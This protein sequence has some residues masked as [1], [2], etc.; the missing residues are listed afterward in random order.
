MIE[1][2]N[3]IIG[4]AIIIINLIPFITK[5]NKYLQITI[6]ISLLITAIRFLFFK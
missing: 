1:Q 2:T 5:K 6:P 3:L 4:I